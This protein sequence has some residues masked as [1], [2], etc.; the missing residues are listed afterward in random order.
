MKRLTAILLAGIVPLIV[1]GVVFAETKLS[2]EAAV[3]ATGV[4][5]L[6]PMGVAEKFPATVGKLYCYSKI[7]GGTE[8][9]SIK[10]IWYRGDKNVSEI[11]LPIKYPSFRTY[12]YKTIP[13]DWTG[14]WKVEIVAN[15][16]TV[17][18]TLEFD[19]E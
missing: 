17:L 14:K 16:G 8:G 4:E 19:V 12:S 5:N 3:I 13:P 1:V 15:D 18:K 6:T 9:S 11:V 2:V 7:V 10:H